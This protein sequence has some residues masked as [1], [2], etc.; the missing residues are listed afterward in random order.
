MAKYGNNVLIEFEAVV[1]LDFGFLKLIQSKY[2]NLKFMKSYVLKA[3]TYF[4]KYLL[5]TRRDPNPLS[6]MINKEYEQDVDQ[7]FK[8]IVASDRSEI[9]ELSSP[10]AIFGLIET[11]KKT[12]GVINCTV[13]CKTQQDEQ[14]IKNLDDSIRT[15]VKGYDIDLSTYDSIFIKDYNDILKYNKMEAKSIFLLKYAFNLE[16][17]KREIPLIKISIFVTDVNKIYLVTPY[18]G[19]KFPEN[20]PEE[21]NVVK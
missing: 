15:I 12:D 21:R 13:L 19:F 18:V 20:L 8:D 16:D 10:T 9:L 2:N 6:V 1:D 7:I 14:Y 4:L 17:D 5:L 11:Y 3:D